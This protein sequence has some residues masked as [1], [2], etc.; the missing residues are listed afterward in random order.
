MFVCIRVYVNV[1]V[2]VLC[3][4]VYFNT[5][6]T[7]ECAEILQGECMY[8]C[9]CVCMFVRLYVY[10]CMC[11]C[12]YVCGVCMCVFL[13][14]YFYTPMTEEWAKMLQGK[15]MYVCVCVFMFVCI[16]VYVYVFVC[17]YT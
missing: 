13:Y 14:T 12:L 8:L 5:P 7:G 11:M 3:V 1:V 6:L 9:V 15:C 4:C 10:A 2:F 16:R 17:P